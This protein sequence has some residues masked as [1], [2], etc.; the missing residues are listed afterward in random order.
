MTGIEEVVA[1]FAAI[2]GTAAVGYGAYEGINAIS[3]G[4]KQKKEQQNIMGGVVPPKPDPN[5][6][7]A[8]AEATLTQSRRSL[9]A[10]GGQTDITGG[11]PILTGNVKSNV[12]LGG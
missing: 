2:A 7:A 4:D 8:A 6:A 12:L 3:G 5:A 1:I 10:A 11:S 9:L